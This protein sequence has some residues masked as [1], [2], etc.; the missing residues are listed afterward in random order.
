MSVHIASRAWK[1][2]VK[3]PGA[4]LVY[5]K[6]AD[7]ANDRGECYPSKAKIAAECEMDERT[8][9]R[10]LAYLERNG[11]ITR[12]PRFTKLNR[13][14][15]D[16]IVLVKA[17]ADLVRETE[18]GQIVSPGSTYDS[19]DVSTDDSGDRLSPLDGQ[20][21]SPRE[22]DCLP[23]E[24]EGGQIVSPGKWVKDFLEGTQGTS[25]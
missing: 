4:K 12:S 22:T 25:S 21:G 15:S 3:D 7:N 11:F 18:G 14:T 23:S 6:L 24:D 8:V 19:T 5:L 10:K 1:H 16:L 2:R 20:V 9:Q 13:R 17:V